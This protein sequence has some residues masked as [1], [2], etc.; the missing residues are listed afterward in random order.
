MKFYRTAAIA[1][2]LCMLFSLAACNAGGNGGTS[3]TAAGDVSSNSPEASKAPDTTKAPEVTDKPE[4]KAPETTKKVET[5][6]PETDPP[7]AA[8]TIPDAEMTIL[9]LAMPQ[10]LPDG[11]TFS[12]LTRLMCCDDEAEYSIS[13]NSSGSTKFVDEAGGAVYGKAVCFAGKADSKDSRGEISI[14]PNYIRDVSGAKGI[15]FYVDFSNVKK[16]DNPEA[17]MCASVT[18]NTNNIRAQG[19]DKATGSAVSYYYADGVWTQTTNINSCRQEIPDN[20]K[21]CMYI[22]ATSYYQTYDGQYWDSATGCFNDFVFVENMRC[23]TDGYTYDA[24]STIIFD[25]I[26]FIK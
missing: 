3:T 21:G 13:G 25:E 1:L 10:T 20:F 2:A 19:P 12:I 14:S 18:I 24:S 26:T 6:V 22:P 5:T 8:D 7:L 16:S 4:T 17:K 11:S 9:R 23:Y 15:L